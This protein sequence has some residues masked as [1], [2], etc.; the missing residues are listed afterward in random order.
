MLN[1]FCPIVVGEFILIMN[2][3]FIKV[4]TPT[5]ENGYG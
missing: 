4:R 2:P 3:Y 1:I 5:L